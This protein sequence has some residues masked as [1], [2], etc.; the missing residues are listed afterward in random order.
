MGESISIEDYKFD[1]FDQFIKFLEKRE[2]SYE[3][4]SEKMLNRL[5]RKA[6]EEDFEITDDL[7]NAAA[8]INTVK[9]KDI[10]RYESKISSLIEKEIASRFLYEKGKIKMG[11]RNDEE[12][13][14]AIDLLHDG[15]KYNSLL[16]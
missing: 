11:L 10:N 15:A 14:E 13:K 5:M 8:K 12:I 2:Y 1:G 4:E 3:S 16:K 9:I 7:K 6:Q